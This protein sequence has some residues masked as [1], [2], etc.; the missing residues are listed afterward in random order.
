MSLNV[1][2]VIRRELSVQSKR[3]MLY[4][5]RSSLA[6]IGLLIALSMMALP[7]NFLGAKMAG[8]HLFN[9]LIGMAYL[10]CCASCFLT[11]DEIG[12]ELRE[13]TLGL[14]FLTP[15]RSVEVLLGKFG[16]CGLAGMSGVVGFAPVLMLPVMQ[17]GVTGGEVV[18][19][20]IVLV[21]TMFLALAVG[22]WVAASGRSPVDSARNALIAMLGINLLPCFFDIFLFG[23]VAPRGSAFLPG[24]L[25]SLSCV[26]DAAYQA[27]PLR[28]YSSI[29]L[30][31]LS[32]WFLV[33]RANQILKANLDPRSGRFFAGGETSARAVSAGA[34]RRIPKGRN[35]VAWLILQNRAYH[36]AAWG[37][38]VLSLLGLFVP[39]FFRMQGLSNIF[40]IQ[41]LFWGLG[42]L[43]ILVLA[44]LASSFISKSRQ[45]GEL[46]MLLTT[47]EGTRAIISG[48]TTALFRLLL[49]PVA[50]YIFIQWLVF[51]SRSWGGSSFLDY[52][53]FL[54]FRVII[55]ILQIMGI[56]SLSLWIGATRHSQR[57]AMLWSLGFGFV[58]PKIFVIIWS[59]GFAKLSR[60]GGI[61]LP[62][63]LPEHIV[64]AAYYVWMIRFSR[65]RLIAAFGKS[66]L[67]DDGL[68]HKAW[69]GFQALRHWTP[70]VSGSTSHES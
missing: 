4:F 34:I 23:F 70:S 49:W 55:L 15:I 54:L 5:H 59:A 7:M 31:H 17:G 3:R 62:Y 63:Y 43:E 9:S 21:N 51:F 12:R 56:C 58:I 16:A 22:L 13:G 1:F 27:Q 20:A 40:G 65:R 24:P 30:T 38:A 2:P 10:M 6:G 50:V 66:N 41:G 44:W 48:Q 8:Q 67:Y 53:W 39:L 32:G 26:Y 33:W 52:I 46:E 25:A 18:R 61:L 69:A 47:P 45:S 57:S 60:G 37:Y 28:Y 36:L 14:L 68:L 11:C 29:L 35:P 19:G 42:L 64:L